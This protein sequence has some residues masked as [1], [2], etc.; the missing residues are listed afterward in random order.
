MPNESHLYAC[1]F[2]IYNQERPI[3]HL[4]VVLAVR[5]DDADDRKYDCR[6]LRWGKGR[7]LHE[8]HE[9]RPQLRRLWR[10]AI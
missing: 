4:H 8:M 5:R 10:P 7:V 9:Q 2:A 1:I 3:L 6:L